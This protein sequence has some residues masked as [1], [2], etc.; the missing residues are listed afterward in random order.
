MTGNVAIYGVAIS[1]I[2]IFLRYAV[3]AMPNPIA[4]SGVAAGALILMA[5]LTMPQLNIG[6]P[7]IAL[8]LVGALF[9]GAAIHLTLKPKVPD[10]GV[11]TDAEPN[12]IGDIHGN[13]GIIT[14]GQEGNNRI[15]PK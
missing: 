2:S 10:S 5:N 4:W 8:F 9:I 11:V 6:L 1:I 12:T 7:G 14:Q 3:P 15:D 13:S